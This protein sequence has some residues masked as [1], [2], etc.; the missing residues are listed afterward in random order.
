MPNANRKTI[1]A[2]PGTL[3]QIV[4]ADKEAAKIMIDSG[5]YGIVSVTIPPGGQVELEVGMITPQIFI[6][7]PDLTGFQGDNVISINKPEGND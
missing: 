6:S 1:S 4:K 2:K 3:I 7:Y 5:A